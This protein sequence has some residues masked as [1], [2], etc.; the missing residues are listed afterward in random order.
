MV[1]VF[2]LLVSVCSFFPLF[3]FSSLVLW[4]TVDLATLD[5]LQGPVDAY[6]ELAFKI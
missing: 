5:I 6:D 2:V 1:G 3:Q 4:E